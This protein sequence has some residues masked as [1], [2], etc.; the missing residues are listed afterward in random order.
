MPDENI[1]DDLLQTME[2]KQQAKKNKI[3]LT[4][5]A[6]NVNESASH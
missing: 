2:Q 6:R 1:A 5:P 4:K 3:L